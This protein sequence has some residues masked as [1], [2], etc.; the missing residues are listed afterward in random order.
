MIVTL[1][2]F[3]PE[4]VREARRVL[5][6]AP[7]AE[8]RVTAGSQA[9]QAKNNEQLSADCDESRYLQQM[10]LRALDRAP[11]FLAAALPRKVFPPRFNRYT[12]AANAF[13]PHVDGAIRFAEQGVRVR[14]DLSCTL[15]L[16]EPDD[17][18]GGELV[19]GGQRLKLAAGQAV[20]YPATTIHEVTPVTRGARIA[21]FFWI[22]SM[23]RSHEQR[24]LLL[25]LDDALTRLRSRHGDDSDT[26]ALT[27]TYHNLLRMWADT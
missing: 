24:A 5:D 23:V 17:Y 7:W 3:T 12:G 20:L 8:G 26:V 15:F 19:T 4:E 10:V 2:L 1:S 11:R 22:E 13:G 9:A 16:S 21:S 25:D 27:G 18:D 6:A 14:S